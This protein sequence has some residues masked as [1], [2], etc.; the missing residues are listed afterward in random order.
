MTGIASSLAV[1][2]RTENRNSRD[3][4]NTCFSSGTLKNP[5]RSSCISDNRYQGVTFA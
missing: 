4:A 5:C 1:S 2:M 3:R